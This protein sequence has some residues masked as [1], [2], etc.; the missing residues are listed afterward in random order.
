MAKLGPSQQEHF[1]EAI[2]QFKVYANKLN[3]LSNMSCALSGN[4][5]GIKMVQIACEHLASLVPYVIGGAQILYTSGSS[6]EACENMQVIRSKWVN[7]IDLLHLAID[8]IT[9]INDFLGTL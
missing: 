4:Q 2:T 8:D 1:N 5:D 3:D 9:C 7:Q 6:K